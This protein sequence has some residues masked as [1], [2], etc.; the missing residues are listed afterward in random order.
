MFISVS[1]VSVFI[2]LV[3]YFR[4][5]FPATAIMY[6]PHFALIASFVSVMHASATYSRFWGR[7]LSQTAYEWEHHIA[8]SWCRMFDCLINTCPAVQSPTKR[9]WMFLLSIRDSQFADHSDTEKC[10]LFKN[11]DW[12][13][14]KYYRK[15]A[16]RSKKIC[17]Q[18]NSRGPV[19][20]RF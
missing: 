16:I 19:S 6:S 1:A 14:D 15:W 18:R 13:M 3:P 17:L 7:A 12:F 5:I 9:I 4:N 2:K 20:H 10:I 11:D 8:A